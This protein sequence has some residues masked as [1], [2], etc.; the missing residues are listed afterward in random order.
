M[1]AAFCPLA[2]T[3]VPFFVHQRGAFDGTA[4]VRRRKQTR[5]DEQ[6]S[7]QT[8]GDFEYKQCLAWR[9]ISSRF[10][11]RIKIAHLRSLAAVLSSF[12]P[13]D[14]VRLS[15]NES[16]RLSLIVKWYDQHWVIISQ[17][18]PFVSLTDEAFR[19]MTLD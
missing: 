5:M 18:L 9:E 11:E 1:T 15:R 4:R 17:V 3:R 12:F 16:R 6:G 7:A 19:K 8:P 10:G 14:L 2:L 13:S